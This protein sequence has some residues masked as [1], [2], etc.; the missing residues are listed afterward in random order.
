[1]KYLIDG[2]VQ[3]HTVPA[4]ENTMSEQTKLT[5]GLGFGL[6][7]MIGAGGIVDLLKHIC[8]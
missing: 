6:F 5:L 4:T 7:M 1:L 8:G 2:V 3:V